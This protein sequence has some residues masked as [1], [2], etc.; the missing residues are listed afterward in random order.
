M[1][2]SAD[3]KKQTTFLAESRPDLPGDA[4]FSRM[5][6]ALS[7]I[8][9]LRSPESGFRFDPKICSHPKNAPFSFS[10]RA[11]QCT[12]GTLI[13][14]KA[15][16]CTISGSARSAGLQ[17][18]VQIFHLIRGK[19]FLTI[20]NR[21]LP[22]PRDSIF[23]NDIAAPLLFVAHAECEWFSMVVP[24]DYFRAHTSAPP[25]AYF[26]EPIML[27][28]SSGRLLKHVLV[29]VSTALDTLDPRDAGDACDGLLCF[30]RPALMKRFRDKRLEEGAGRHEQLRN[31][32]ENVM[33]KWLTRPG[34][35]M[36]D[37]ADSCGISARLLTLIFREIGT[38]PAAYLMRLRLEHAAVYLREAHIKP[39]AISEVAECCG[40]QSPAHFSRAFKAFFGMTP[41]DMK[42]R[43]VLDKS[44]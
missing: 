40:F 7:R 44:I 26:A 27:K 37:I 6:E 23:I 41:R 43:A 15:S 35:T 21:T 38:T 8:G 5:L 31:D 11:T 4:N 2:P 19:A 33:L 17:Q 20:Q 13:H 25:L 3:Q 9:H 42:K 24:S 16:P 39:L 10:L 1:Q 36:Q 32:A 30:L 22:F 34:V 28:E 14:T 18:Y 12:V 29:L